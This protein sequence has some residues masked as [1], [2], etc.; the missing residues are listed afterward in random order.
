MDFAAG[1]CVSPH[2]TAFTAIGDEQA[3]R[4]AYGRWNSALRSMRRWLR[5]HY[6]R[7]MSIDFVGQPICPWWSF[8]TMGY[9]THL[10][11]DILW[12]KSVVAWVVCP[13]GVLAD[14]HAHLSRRWEV[15]A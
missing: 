3:A 5:V 8:H 1:S 15:A 10:A 11:L 13:F 7:Q 2:T 4:P 12:P 9:G 6:R 14:N